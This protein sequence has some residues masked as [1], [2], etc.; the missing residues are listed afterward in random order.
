[1][2]LPDRFVGCFLG[3]AL[4]DALGA[5]H[6]G[7]P[8]EKLA[9]RLICLP[10]GDL[11]R[12]TDDTQMT[13]GL[14]ESLIEKDG[15]DCDHLAQGWAR[16]LEVLRGYG[17]STRRILAAVRAGRP[18]REA[19]RAL[20]PQGSFGNGA[21][22]RAAPI[23][24]FFRDEPLLMEDAA[25]RSSEITHAHPLGVEGGVLMARAAA[26][27]LRPDFSPKGFLESLLA[28]ARAEEYRARL[29]QALAWLGRDPSAAEVRRVLGSSVR[30]HES[31]VTALYCFCR[32]P[33]D[34]GAMAEFS[35]S[36][37][38]DTD[39]LLSMAGG[40]FGARNGS[41]ALPHDL[42]ARLE[43]RDE[44]ERL[45]RALCAKRPPPLGAR[46]SP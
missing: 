41:P 2:D 10:H 31:A 30:A 39:T 4:G 21:A 27:T 12:W 29:R 13:M 3:L 14:A 34:F 19:G 15:V 36:L 26:L 1:M 9:W 28:G 20:F 7:G 16:R 6:E 22:M 24:L 33:G 11:L 43:A 23:G 35:L 25:I 38:G 32:F 45:A 42:L 37:D 5:P 44:L 46:L 17:P 40:L 18:W 8:F